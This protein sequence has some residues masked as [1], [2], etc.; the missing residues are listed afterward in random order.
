MQDY[1]LQ[2]WLQKDIQL[3]EYLGKLVNTI[4][5]YLGTDLS[6]HNHTTDVGFN[7]KFIYP[8]REESPSSASSSFFSSSLGEAGD[9][10]AV[11]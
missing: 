10:A 9:S 6:I 4:Y 8:N 5:Q 7:I 11:A 3:H 1:Y 2:T